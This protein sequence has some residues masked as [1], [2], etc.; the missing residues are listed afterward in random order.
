MAAESCCC[1]KLVWEWRCR[2]TRPP[3]FWCLWLRYIASS[4]YTDFKK[5]IKHLEFSIKKS[6]QIIRDTKLTLI[7]DIRLPAY[8]AH[9]NVFTREAW[10][11]FIPSRRD[12]SAEDHRQTL[13]RSLRAEHPR[14]TILRSGD[15]KNGTTNMQL[16]KLR[17]GKGF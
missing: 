17:V 3:F 15:I 2:E 14:V 11:D 8:T 12:G 7:R 6:L 4:T 1:V 10:I 9:T 5:Y 16:W 13:V